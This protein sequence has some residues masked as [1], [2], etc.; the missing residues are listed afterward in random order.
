MSRGPDSPRVLVLSSCWGQ[1]GS[2][3]G[4]S[5]RSLAAAISRFFSVDVLVKSDRYDQATDGLFD[6]SLIKSESVSGLWPDST[7]IKWPSNISKRPQIAMVDPG[8]EDAVNLI[9]SLD[10]KSVIIQWGLPNELEVEVNANRRQKEPLGTNCFLELVEMDMLA[11]GN[12]KNDPSQRKGYNQTP[13]NPG[14]FKPRPLP[15]YNFVGV[16]LPVNPLAKS[17]RHLGIGFSDYVLVLTNRDSTSK[18]D[19]V[20]PE[21]VL[22]ITARFP[23]ENILLVEDGL[24]TVVRGR[25][26]RGT[27]AIATRTD[28]WR[29]IANAKVTV[30]LKPGDLLGRECIESLQYGTPIIVPDKTTAALFAKAGGGLWFSNLDQLLCCLE[31]INDPNIRSILGSQGCDLVSS[32]YASSSDFVDRVGLALKPI[33]ANIS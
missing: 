16:H 15:K 22:W 21:S 33:V 19:S 23:R 2:E 10:P 3:A 18:K 26:I 25:S 7:K 12:L 27:V 6:L 17:Q 8:D 31:T 11:S 20:L 4:L 28:L 5:V 14:D 24:A 1:T 9:R 29:L 30:D 13:S 32:R